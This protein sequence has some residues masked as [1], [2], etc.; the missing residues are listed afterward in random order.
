MDLEQ[1]FAAPDI[2]LSAT[3]KHTVNLAGLVGTNVV[4]YFYPR[5]N[6]P[7]CTTEG[8]N[9]RDH[10]KAFG[11]AKTLIFGVSRD[12]VK[13]HQTFKE[14]QNFP[15]ELLSDPEEK[16]CRALDV[17]REK[18]LYGKTYMGI[19]RSTFLF[20]RQGELVQQW[21]KVKVKGHV[22]I[23]LQAAQALA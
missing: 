2:E 5:D 13:S 11:A 8:Q 20:D 9:F 4:V 23:V 10:F 16:L 15:F 19:D 21:R 14:K 12:S 22:E 1:G 7:G 17:I 18:K 3:G 6:T